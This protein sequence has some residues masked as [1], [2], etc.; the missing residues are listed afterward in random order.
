M[1]Y[2]LLLF[3]ILIFAA[4]NNPQ[5]ETKIEPIH[6]DT[7]SQNFFPIQDFLKS[8]IAAVNEASSGIKKYTSTG[9][10]KD[11]NYIQLDEFSRLAQ[12]FLPNA[13][14]DSIFKKEFKE[15][16]FIDKATEG[17]T[18]FYSTSNPAIALKR[19]DVV[20]QK[21]DSYDKVKSIYLEKISDSITKKLYWKPGRNFQII[22]LTPKGTEL[23]K[24]VWDNR[25]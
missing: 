2:P 21:T 6:T 8:E 16:S 19:A 15:T 10:K 25:E 5:P 20:T 17:G 11:S 13:L 24:V 7:T 1:K 4:C 9:N 14:N 23:I 18:F 22:S 3:I 12:E